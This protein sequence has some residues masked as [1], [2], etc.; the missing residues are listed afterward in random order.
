MRRILPLILVVAAVLGA[1]TPGAG[2]ASYRSCEPVRNPYPHTRHAGV[3]LTHI[4]ALR[5]SCAT[6]RRVARGA[7]RRGL[8]RT[9]TGVWRFRWHGWGVT[10]D[11][12]PWPARERYV[13]R[14]GLPTRG[15]RW[16]FRGA[17]ASSR[18]CRPVRNPYPRSRYAGVDL[19]RIRA[20]RVS[21]ATARRV[22][23][24]AHRRALGMTPTVSGIRTFTW[25][26]WRVRGD[27]RGAHDRYVA[28]RDTRR[29][30]WRF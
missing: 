30:R 11:L 21:C 16:R 25:H 7:Q 12:L 5:V 23:R 24:G 22:A 10:G 17:A 27:L 2:A 19:T 4:R 28:R 13:A 15:V 9:L 18:S 20:L 26:G 3:D 6:A 1:T 14:E 8:E 29:V